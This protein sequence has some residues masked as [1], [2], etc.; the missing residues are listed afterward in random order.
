[1]IMLYSV[2]S[3]TLDIFWSMYTVREYYV[4]PF[5]TI[6]VLRYPKIHAYALDSSNKVSYIETSIN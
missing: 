4:L 6:L 3:I 5:P 2:Q 1:M